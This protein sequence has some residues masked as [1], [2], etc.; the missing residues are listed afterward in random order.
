MPER[1]HSCP[2]LNIS[3]TLGS[4]IFG[5]TPFLGKR[6]NCTTGGEENSVIAVTGLLE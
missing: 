5:V 3:P 4:A 1:G 2:G 6:G